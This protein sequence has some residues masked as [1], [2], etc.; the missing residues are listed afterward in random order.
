VQAEGRA[1]DHIVEPIID[2]DIAKLTAGI[3]VLSQ[4][5]HWNAKLDV[6]RLHACH[7]FSQYMLRI[8]T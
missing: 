3:L 4:H 6:P 1:A 8:R 7:F 5:A 2:E